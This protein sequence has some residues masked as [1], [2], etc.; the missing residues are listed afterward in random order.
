MGFEVTAE[1]PSFT[2]I[3]HVQSVRIFFSGLTIFRFFR[4]PG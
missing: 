2:I 4:N 1:L 3:T